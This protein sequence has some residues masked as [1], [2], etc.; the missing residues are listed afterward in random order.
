MASQ[1]L[2]R[3]GDVLLERIMA[4]KRNVFISFDIEDEGMVRFLVHQAKDGRFPFTFRDYSVKEP[5]ESRWKRRVSEKISQTS[6][7]IVAIG[8]NTYKS[9]AVNW[10]ID[11]AYGQYKKIIGIRLHRYSNHILPRAIREYGIR[12]IKWNTRDIARELR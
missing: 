9:R 7:V 5:F 3:S 4:H 6:A 12:V 11:E 1:G 10:E 2:L 8:R